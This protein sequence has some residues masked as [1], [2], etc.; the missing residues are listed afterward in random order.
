MINI[1]NEKE[2]GKKGKDERQKMKKESIHSFI[3]SFT[4]NTLLEIGCWS[5]E[6]RG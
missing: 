4:S 1:K 2:E 5:I 6:R 3:H